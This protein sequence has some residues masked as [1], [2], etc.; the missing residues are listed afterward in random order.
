MGREA[1]LSQAMRNVHALALAYIRED[2]EAI[3]VLLPEMSKDHRGHWLSALG[4]IA[5][6]AETVGEADGISGKS[7]LQGS[8]LLEAADEARILDEDTDD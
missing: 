7:V 8:A 6:L 1:E 3:K 4:I 2:R 5:A